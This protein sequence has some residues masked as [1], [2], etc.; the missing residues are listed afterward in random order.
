MNVKTLNPTNRLF[1]AI[2]ISAALSLSG[3]VASFASDSLTMHGLI[4]QVTQANKQV[5][6][7]RLMELSSQESAR[8]TGRWPDPMLMLGI[9]NAPKS[10]DLDMDPMT[11]RVIG[12]SQ[13]IPYSGSRSLQRKAAQFATSESFQDRL[14]VERNLIYLARLAYI[15]LYA[16]RQT[17]LLLE[18]QHALLEQI[19][20]ANL[21]ALEANQ[22]TQDQVLSARSDVWR[23]QV[24]I[25]S[26]KQEIDALQL[27]LNSLRGTAPN[28]T[29]PVLA[30]PDSTL[31]TD[32]LALWLDAAHS[33]YPPLA[34]LAASSS[35]Y[36]LEAQASSRMRWPMLSLSAEYGIRTG[37]ETDLHGDP[38]EER[39]DMVSIGALISLPIFSRGG[40]ASMARSMK[41]MSA[42]QSAQADQVWRET[43]SALRA[44]HQRLNRTHETITLYREKIIPSSEDISNVTLS[45][46]EAN[47]V[48]LADLLRTEISVLNDQSTLI[49]LEAERF[50]T[51]AEI[52]LYIEPSRD[53]TVISSGK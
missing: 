9:E 44:L 8:A 50:R 45:G 30:S 7:A 43:E 28:D 29:I 49:A 5:E 48:T 16:K 33:N 23:S 11:M 20:E 53:T 17:L 51:E 3:P 40:Q 10:F 2:A 18:H 1:R 46:Y 21:N 13:E 37:R 39:E 42:S 34:K 38:G 19:V 41:A 14:T 32:S 25:L 24:S 12:L 6:S 27:R 31:E 52:L 4:T 22:T 15:D 26:L 35:R 36:E 47:R